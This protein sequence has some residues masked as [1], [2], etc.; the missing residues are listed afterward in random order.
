MKIDMYDFKEYMN[1]WLKGLFRIG[2]ERGILFT[3]IQ[4]G[5]ECLVSEK[6]SWIFFAVQVK[7]V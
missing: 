3:D 4:I 5:S 6:N 1:A 7:I 2:R